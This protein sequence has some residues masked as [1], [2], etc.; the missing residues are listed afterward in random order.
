MSLPPETKRSLVDF[1]DSLKNHIEKIS[2][3]YRGWFLDRDLEIIRKL[4]VPGHWLKVTRYADRLV[5]TCTHL[6]TLELCPTKDYMDIC[7]GVISGDC[8]N[9]GTG[10]KSPS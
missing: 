1:L 8:V 6:A 5:K 10:R 2:Q 9:D 7:K 3:V 4:H